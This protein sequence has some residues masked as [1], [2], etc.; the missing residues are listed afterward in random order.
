M[1][2]INQSSEM[3]LFWKR[4]PQAQDDVQ[5]Q[6]FAGENQALKQPIIDQAS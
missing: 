4:D 2:D 6:A 1:P 5:R 3:M